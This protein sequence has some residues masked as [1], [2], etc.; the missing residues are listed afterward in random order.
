[1]VNWI[2]RA[3]LNVEE[4]GFAQEEY[5]RVPKTYLFGDNFALVSQN[6]V[7]VVGNYGE[8]YNRNLVPSSSLEEDWMTSTKAEQVASQAKSLEPWRRKVFSQSIRLMK[9][10]AEFDPATSTSYIFSLSSIYASR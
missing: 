10:I 1:M 8:V 6:A 2:V 7:R 5:T 3:L 4:Q 9:P